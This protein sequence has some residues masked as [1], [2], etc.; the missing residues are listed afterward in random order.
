MGGEWLEVKVEMRCSPPGRGLS[1]TRR[2]ETSRELVRGAMCVCDTPVIKVPTV[3]HIALGFCAGK[4]LFHLPS[5]ELTCS[6]CQL[7]IGHIN[8]WMVPG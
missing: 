2:L 8:S 6:T 7:E 4:E 1:E 5:C 3:P